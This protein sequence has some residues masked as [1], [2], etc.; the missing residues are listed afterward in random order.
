VAQKQVVFISRNEFVCIDLPTSEEAINVN[1]VGE[2]TL[3]PVGD[4]SD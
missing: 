2:Q 3:L 1:T 4:V